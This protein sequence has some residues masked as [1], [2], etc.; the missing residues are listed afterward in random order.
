MITEPLTAQEKLDAVMALISDT[1]MRHSQY[2]E[3][4]KRRRADA[5][6]VEDRRKYETAFRQNHFAEIVLFTLL[7]TAMEVVES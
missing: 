3:R 4:Y 2:A 7:S 1:R 6:S 5:T